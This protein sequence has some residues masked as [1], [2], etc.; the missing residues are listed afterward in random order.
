MGAN[1]LLTDI[2]LTAAARGARSPRRWPRWRH[3]SSRSSTRFTSRR[4]CSSFYTALLRAPDST[5]VTFQCHLA[6]PSANLFAVW[7]LEAVGDYFNAQ[8]A[9]AVAN[10]KAAL[11]QKAGR[12]ILVQ[13]QTDPG[14]PNP[15][16]LPRF[17]IGLPPALG[18]Q[19]WS[20][21]HDCGDGDSWTGRATSR[22]RPRES[23]A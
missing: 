5:L 11:P 1:P 12:L 13:A 20:P 3:A 6:I 15:Q 17:N 21:P 14:S 19:P 8:I 10:T 2:L 4:G 23:S 9:T 22:S 16:Q 7:Q 18:R